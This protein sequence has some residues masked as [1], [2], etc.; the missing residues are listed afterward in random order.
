MTTLLPHPLSVL[1]VSLLL[2][3]RL[4]VCVS[5]CLCVSLC[6]AERQ[7]MQQIMWKVFETVKNHR[8]AWPFQEP[9]DG[10]TVPDYYEIIKDPIG[11]VA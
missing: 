10:S 9:V 8:D 7:R 5:M 11:T 1:Y 2:T 3:S 4:S 6:R